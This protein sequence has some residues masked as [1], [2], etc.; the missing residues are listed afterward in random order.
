[1]RKV[2]S[3]LGDIAVSTDPAAVFDARSYRV[4]FSLFEKLAPD[5]QPV[6]SVEQSVTAMRRCIDE[7]ALGRQPFRMSRYIRLNHLRSLKKSGYVD[8][9]LRSAAQEK[10][11]A[12]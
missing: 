10:L 5:H 11:G 12:P 1:A 7:L 3:I 4:D 2:A 6:C 9:T 8:D